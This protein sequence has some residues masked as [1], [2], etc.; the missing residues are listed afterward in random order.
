MEDVLYRYKH[1]VMPSLKNTLNLHRRSWHHYQQQYFIWKKVKPCCICLYWFCVKASLMSRKKTEI[2]QKQKKKKKSRFT[3]RILCLHRYW[4]DKRG[5][6][7]FALSFNEARLK[8]SDKCFYY[9]N[10]G[11]SGRWNSLDQTINGIHDVATVHELCCP[12]WNSRPTEEDLLNSL[13]SQNVRYLRL[14]LFR[15]KCWKMKKKM[16]W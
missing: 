14:Y 6:R 15:I 8:A 3:S 11:D 12:V 1:H 5:C 16:F 7:Y 4:K 2:K 10:L 13:S 9:K